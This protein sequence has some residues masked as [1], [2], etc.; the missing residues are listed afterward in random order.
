MACGLT[1]I[2][3]TISA[4]SV[5]SM[6]GRRWGCAPLTIVALGLFAKPGEESLAAAASIMLSCQVGG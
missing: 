6:R 2:N 3:V 4:S 1:F 5:V